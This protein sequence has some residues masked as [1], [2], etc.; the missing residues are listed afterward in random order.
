MFIHIIDNTHSAHIHTVY[1]MFKVWL[2]L[3]F[4]SILIND[5][6]RLG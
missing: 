2:C 6:V 1:M 5:Y 4:A 3:T